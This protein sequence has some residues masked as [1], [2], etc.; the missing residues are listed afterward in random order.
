MHFGTYAKSSKET[1]SLEISDIFCYSGCNVEV[2]SKAIHAAVD[3]DC[4]A[5]PSCK[6][7][8]RKGERKE[9]VEEEKQEEG[10]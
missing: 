2:N 7:A 6:Q 4:G 5:L 1:V 10:Q 8:E 3:W 9:E